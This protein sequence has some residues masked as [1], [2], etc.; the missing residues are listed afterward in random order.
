MKK[1]FARSKKFKG[2]F[3]AFFILSL[4]FLA[5]GLGTL[6]SVYAPGKAY[7]LEAA[8]ESSSEPGVVFEIYNSSLPSDTTL[9]EVY[10]DVAIIYAEPGTPAA[11]TIQR[12]S[13]SNSFSMSSYHDTLT[14]ENFYTAEQDGG[15]A[16]GPEIKDG[17]Y[18]FVPFG[19]TGW[20]VSSTYC[21]V[22]LTATGGA[23]VL[24]NE[25]VFV[26]ETGSGEE[27][28]RFVIEDVKVHAA[29]YHENESAQAGIDRAGA[30]ID[31]QPKSVPALSQ[32]TFTRFSQSEIPTLMTISEMRRNTYA[33]DAAGAPLHHAYHADE[34]YG[35]FGTDF[36]A[37]GAAI[38]GMS[39]FGVRFFPM[40]AAFGAL[41]VLS[42]FVKRLFR[43]EKAAFAFSLLYMLSCI[44]LSLAHVGAPLM[45][46]VFFFSCAL[47]LTHRFY[48]A[49][50][51]RV[52]FLSLMPLLG[53]GLFCAA[54]ICTNGAFLIP[55][56][57][58]AV[59]FV[60]GLVR[61]QKAKRYHLE[62]IIEEPEPAPAPASSESEGAAPAPESRE[63]RAAKVIA[64]YRLKNTSA[65][66]LFFAGLIVGCFLFSLIGMVP[67]YFAYQRFYDNPAAPKLNLFAMS[68][69]TFANGFI[70]KNPYAGGAG[71]SIFH[72][73]FRGSGTVYAVT[74]AMVNWIAVLAVVV[75]LVFAVVRIAAAW[76]QRADEKKFRTELR[77]T[78]IPFAG[79][80]LSLLTA[81]CVK[82]PLGFILLA[83][84]FGFILAAGC[85]GGDYEGK[86]AKAFKAVNV[87]GIVLL[88][89]V[90]ALLAVFTFSI[91]L[92]ASL[93]ESIF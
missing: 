31:A 12:G 90:F 37:L 30:L 33:T 8:Q 5:V 34:V 84:L 52:S 39:Q 27:A 81:L 71:W 42:R 88:A 67:A 18:H 23:N 22:G 20:S 66:V 6:G 38:F 46:G 68:W 74:G 54:A 4:A 11:L 26:G 61:Q 59:L 36:L 10:V 87:A 48:A 35:A 25:I 3:L 7:E 51:K 70:G 64:E 15:N 86:A 17:F 44:T 47:S 56:A 2:F 57:G 13:R 9:A 83:W 76:K 14:F 32:S 58:V 28:E 62:K 49:G 43:S 82:T 60:L 91:P 69:K 55:V 24:V 93:L 65:G 89:A 80:A 77:R 21:Y 16:D 19:I 85:F 50:I 63:K 45:I 72:T 41:I 53:A 79:L 29:T 1:T 92:P 73:L 40:L 75:G 78:L